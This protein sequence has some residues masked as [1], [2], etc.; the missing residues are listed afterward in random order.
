ML[1]SSGVAV[2]KQRKPE[3]LILHDGNKKCVACIF[4]I[5]SVCL[6]VCLHLGFINDNTSTKAGTEMKPT[7][8]RIGEKRA[9]LCAIWY[10][11]LWQD[12]WVSL[13]GFVTYKKCSL[14]FVYYDCEIRN[15]KHSKTVD[16]RFC[17]WTKRHTSLKRWFI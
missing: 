1:S 17:M 13:A 4:L 16:T 7:I 6:S 15:A 3:N 8:A 10:N 5:Q 12:W 2:K 9:V 14:N 11:A